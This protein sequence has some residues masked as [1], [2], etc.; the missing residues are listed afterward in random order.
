MR[1]IG[2]VYVLKDTAGRLGW[3]GNLGCITGKVSF[4]KGG[5]RSPSPQSQVATSVGGIQLHSFPSDV[6]KT[7]EGLISV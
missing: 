5:R 3:I 7:L 6:S 1:K 2:S 4:E